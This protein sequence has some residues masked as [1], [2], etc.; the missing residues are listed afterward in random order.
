MTHLCLTVGRQGGCRK[1]SHKWAHGLGVD[2]AAIDLLWMSHSTKHICILILLFLTHYTL[3]FQYCFC[4]TL[5][6][7]YVTAL[8]HSARQIYKPLSFLLLLLRFP[9]A[10]TSYVHESKASPFQRNYRGWSVRSPQ[11][12]RTG[13]EPETPKQRLEA[14]S[15]VKMGKRVIRSTTTTMCR[16]C[17]YKNIKYT[18]TILLM[19]TFLC[20]PPPG[21]K[22]KRSVWCCHRGVVSVPRFKLPL[23]GRSIYTF[24]L[25]IGLNK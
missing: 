5:Y 3:K 25:E 17:H 2:L 11:R 6:W 8:K 12:A 18:R 14:P 15:A 23:L 16:Q 1:W 20:H 21:E 19:G 9:V 13:V 24:Y 7:I 10:F 4:F 22:E